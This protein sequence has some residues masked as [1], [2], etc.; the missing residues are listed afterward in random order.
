[1]LEE[2]IL[3]DFN[4]ARKQKDQIMASTLS[5]LRAALINAAIE[6]RKKSLE[7]SDVISILKR[8]VKERQD[9]IEQ[10]KKGN[11]LDLVEKET[12][13]LQILKSYLP[14]QLTE[15]ELLP[16]IQEALNSTGAKDI[17]SMGMVI[18]EVISKTKSQADGSLVSELVKKALTKTQTS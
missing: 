15:A 12:K 5:F 16:I 11:R 7:D 4:E 10:F 2:K 9:S 18:K 1:M 17:K 14:K 6:K 8:Q 3:K 13:E